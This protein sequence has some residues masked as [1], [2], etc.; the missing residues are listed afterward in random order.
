MFIYLYTCVY[1]YIFIDIYEYVY[2]FIPAACR[3]RAYCSVVP[4]I[5]PRCLAIALPD[6]M[7]VERTAI[8]SAQQ[9]RGR[10]VVPNCLPDTSVDYHTAIQPANPKRETL[11]PELESRDALAA[12]LEAE[13]LLGEIKKL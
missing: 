3:W 1:V 8:R 10:S 4:R 12:V 13:R 9:E 5:L 6:T 2:M 11:K 7:N